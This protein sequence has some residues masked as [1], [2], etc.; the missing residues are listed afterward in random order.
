MRLKNQEHLSK[1]KHL[2]ASCKSYVAINIKYCI[3]HIN[4]IYGRCIVLLDFL[5]EIIEEETRNFT[6]K[7]VKH[8]FA[9][10]HTFAPGSGCTVLGVLC[11]ENNQCSRWTEGNNHITSADQY[12]L[13][14]WGSHIWEIVFQSRYNPILPVHF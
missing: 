11:Q 10:Q 1:L 4:K 3:N 6:W 2:K 8:T 12:L 9:F 14:S 5:R 7:K 13:Q